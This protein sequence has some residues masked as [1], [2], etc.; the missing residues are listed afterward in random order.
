MSCQ[1]SV[2][3]LSLRE[4]KE[5]RVAV[6]LGRNLDSISRR[7]SNCLHRF[8]SSLPR[9]AAT[10]TGSSYSALPST[11]STPFIAHLAPSPPP[12]SSPP[13]SRLSH[14]SH[15]P[16][17][18]AGTTDRSSIVWCIRLCFDKRVW[19]ARRASSPSSFPLPPFL[20]SL[21]PLL[22]SNR[23]ADLLG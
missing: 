14:L 7:E 17:R 12:I 9:L 18:P 19:R 6:R 16:G 13:D 15:R 10:I 22:P 5:K 21:L 20:L 23:S 11:P 8:S 2:A 4:C 3:L 1:R